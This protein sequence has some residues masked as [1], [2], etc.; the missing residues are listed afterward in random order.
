MSVLRDCQDVIKTV[1]ILLETTTV[2]VMMD[3]T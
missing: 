2:A 3:L 1:S